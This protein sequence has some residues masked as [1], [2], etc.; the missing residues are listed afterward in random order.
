MDIAHIK[1]IPSQEGHAPCMLDETAK[2]LYL[3]RMAQRYVWWK[4]PE[5]AIQYP[6]MVLARTM[7]MGL[8]EDLCELVQ[9][10]SKEELR[11]VLETAVIGQF[12]ARSWHFWYYRL[13]DCA[14]GEVPTLP[15]RRNCPSTTP[16]LKGGACKEK[17]L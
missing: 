17:F 9:V 14:L 13:T 15:V 2:T 5:V 11:K 12:N 10:F 16:T 4:T 7:N 1:P 6:Q 8:W 3:L